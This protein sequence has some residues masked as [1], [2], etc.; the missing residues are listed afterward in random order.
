MRRTWSC[1][2]LSSKINSFRGRPI[3]VTTLWQFRSTTVELQGHWFFQ[4][5]QFGGLLCVKPCHS[6]LFF[7]PN[8]YQHAL[9]LRRWHQCLKRRGGPVEKALCYG[10]FVSGDSYG[11]YYPC[12]AQISL[13]LLSPL[14]YFVFVVFMDFFGHHLLRNWGICELIWTLNQWFMACFIEGIS[15]GFFW[16]NCDMLSLSYLNWVVI[17]EICFGWLRLV[18]GVKSFNFEHPWFKWTSFV[19]IC[20]FF[21]YPSMSK[22]LTIDCIMTSVMAYFLFVEALLKV[23]NQFSPQVFTGYL[24]T[25]TKLPHGAGQ[26][27]RDFI[28]MKTFLFHCKRIVPNPGGLITNLRARQWGPVRDGISICRKYMVV[29]WIG[30]LFEID[31]MWYLYCLL[32]CGCPWKIYLLCM[33]WWEEQSNYA[34]SQ[35]LISDRSIGST[36]LYYVCF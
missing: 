8:L 4:F 10:F 24:R 36:E 11:V 16:I 5:Q 34:F 19:S 18:I 1:K 33:H 6:H 21:L 27:F 2:S 26:I 3:V 12:E 35:D 22:A 7:G 17:V 13:L 32:C 15:D 14:F 29:L 23:S 28:Q 31:S 25:A 30:V 20:G 9:N